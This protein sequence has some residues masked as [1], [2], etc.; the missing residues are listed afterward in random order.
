[1]V[2]EIRVPQV[3]RQTTVHV[4]DSI[5]LEGT[6]YNVGKLTMTDWKYTYT[7][8]RDLSEQWE[9]KCIVLYIVLSS[10]FF[11]R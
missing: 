9:A 2:L 5:K 7:D 6:T 11:I 3:W 1:M 8:P 10:F 4:F